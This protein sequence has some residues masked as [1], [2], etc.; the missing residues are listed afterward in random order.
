MLRRVTTV[1]DVV[2]G[3]F[4][5]WVAVAVLTA[6]LVPD[7]VPTA[8]K[9][10]VVGMQLAALIVGGRYGWRFNQDGKQPPVPA[11]GGTSVRESNDRKRPGDG[12]EREHE[13][14]PILR[15]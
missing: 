7:D 2:V 4:L 9:T 12:Q 10:V 15:P 1:L 5:C 3:A 14:S 11:E 8:A 13:G 6:F